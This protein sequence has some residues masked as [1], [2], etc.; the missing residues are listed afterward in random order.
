L[1]TGTNVWPLDAEYDWDVSCILTDPLAEYIQNTTIRDSFAWV[2]HTFTHENL[3]NSTY[4]DTYKEITYNQQHAINIG[5]S[6]AARW[7]SH[8]LIPPAITGLHNGDALRAFYD[9]GISFVVGDSTRPA[10]CNPVNPY[11]PLNTTIEN[12]GFA[13]VQIMPRWSTRIYW[14]WYSSTMHINS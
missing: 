9:N 2:S 12:N 6:Q 1:G 11:W 14:D 8:G 10:L 7:S 13:G 4:V 3:E 5:L